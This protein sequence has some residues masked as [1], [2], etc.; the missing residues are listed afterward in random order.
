MA[1]K[2]DGLT[3]AAECIG[4]LAHP[5]RIRMVQLLLSGKHS[6]GELAD[7]CGVPSPVASGH[8]RLMQ[9]VGLLAPQRDGRNVYYKI[10]EPALPDLIAVLKRR[11]TKGK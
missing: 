1:A 10:T 7:A 2:A 11:F 9:R 4:T 8:L 5:H 6:V 3:R